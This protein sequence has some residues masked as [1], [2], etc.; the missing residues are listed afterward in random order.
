VSGRG[1]RRCD[2]SVLH[3]GIVSAGA[4]SSKARDLP[5]RADSAPKSGR[6]LWAPRQVPPAAAWLTSI[7]S[8]SSSLSM[9]GAPQSGLGELILRVRSRISAFVLGRPGRRDRLYAKAF[10]LSD[11]GRW[12]DE[13]Q[14]IEALR[15]HSV[16]QRP[17]RRSAKKRRRRGGR[18]RLRKIT[19]CPRARILKPRSC[20]FNCFNRVQRLRRGK[21][22][23]RVATASHTASARLLCEPQDSPSQPTH[24]SYAISDKVR[25]RNTFSV[26]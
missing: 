15:L 13:Y 10:A 22:R 16:K 14:G 18:C 5:R 26:R 21:R 17:E 23:H 12:F 7:P 25:S 9:R 1:A 2:L 19:R 3:D 4:F 11:H 24:R 6:E 20:S 8:L